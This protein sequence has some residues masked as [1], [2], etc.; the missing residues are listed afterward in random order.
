MVGG[1]VVGLWGGEAWCGGEVR[2]GVVVWD[3]GRMA[4]GDG[5]MLWCGA[6]VVAWGVVWKGV[7]HSVCCVYFPY[8][9]PSS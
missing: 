4:V 8:G 1:G 2:L 7:V 5:V 9:L 3:G 6:E